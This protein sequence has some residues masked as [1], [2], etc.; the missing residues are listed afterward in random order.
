VTAWTAGAA[1]LAPAKINLYLKVLGLRPDG[2]HELDT[3]MA[4]LDVADR[5]WICP[6]ESREDTLEAVESPIILPPGFCGPDNLTLKA[7]AAFR[8]QT[9]WP[10][11]GLSLRIEKNIPL[12]AGLGGGSSDC[13][14]VLSRLNQLA[15]NPLN[16]KELEAMGLTLGADVPFFLQPAPIARAAGV[17]ER[18]SAPPKGFEVWAGAEI[19][20]VN[21]GL[22]LSTAQVFK[23]W[24]LTN[25]AAKNN[26]APISQPP[27]VGENS[28]LASARML[29]SELETVVEAIEKFRPAAWGLSGSG[30]TFW[31]C[32]PGV[33]GDFGRHPQWWVRSVK[34]A[35][36]P[37]LTGC[38]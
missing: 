35:Q 11:Q 19:I 32:E 14:A 27:R 26:L 18:F 1:T 23:N 37:G 2:Y 9:G 15:P 29:A 5:L 36:Y 3:V 24:D 8:R 28:L 33:A 7:A 10:E 20:L 16:Q 13:A 12:G 30:P 22:H 34:I 17:G 38:D 31:L 25:E 6:A 21:P 4:R